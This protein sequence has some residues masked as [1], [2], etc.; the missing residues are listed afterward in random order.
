ME[1]EE[2]LINIE[3]IKKKFEDK[4]IFTEEEKKELKKRRNTSGTD[5]ITFAKLFLLSYDTFYNNVHLIE[6]LEFKKLLNGFNK[7]A[8]RLRILIEDYDTT[9]INKYFPE[10]KIR[11]NIDRI[12][13]GVLV[14]Y[15]FRV[16]ME[17]EGFLI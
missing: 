2:Q 14:G 1:N 6:D 9:E 3:N 8:N 5:S 7:N 10:L 15:F 17:E 12:K 13:M 4:E 16:F 11:C